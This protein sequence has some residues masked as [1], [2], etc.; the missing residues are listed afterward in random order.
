MQGLQMHPVMLPASP[1]VSSPQPAFWA[2][3]KA[4][5]PTNLQELILNQVHY[6]FSTENLLRDEFLRNHMH[7]EEGW[8][9]IHLLSTFNRLRHLTTDVRLITEVRSYGRL[10]PTRPM[11][12]PFLAPMP[13]ATLTFRRHSRSP[14]SWR[15]AM[16]RSGSGTIGSVGSS[17]RR[18]RAPARKRVAA[19]PGP[20]TPRRMRLQ[21]LRWRRARRRAR[22]SRAQSLSQ[23]QKPRAQTLR[24]GGTQPQSS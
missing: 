13:H 7:P 18:R 17:L 20:P 12:C 1:Y 14:P 15:F 22:R 2:P 5:Y 24:R 8:I 23:W 11:A 6:Y 4:V 19:T 21:T 9:S 10:L 3:A 16:A